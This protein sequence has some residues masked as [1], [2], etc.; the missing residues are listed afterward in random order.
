MLVFDSYAWVEYF[1]GSRSGAAVMEHLEG[2][3]SIVTPDIV[4]A[5]IARK[6]IREGISAE[7]TKK[8]L[9]FIAARSEI[10]GIDADLSLSAAKA[11]SELMRRAKREKLGRPSLTDAIVLAMARCYGGKLLT[12][13]AHLLQLPEVVPL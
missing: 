11:W 3:E 5:E 2:R 12:G 13:D 8:R 7:E 10:K 6:Y 4:L 1:I 9:Y